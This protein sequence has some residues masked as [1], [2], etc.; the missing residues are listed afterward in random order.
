MS[1]DA[2]GISTFLSPSVTSLV[3]S[4]CLSLPSLFPFLYLLFV[5][6]FLSSLTFLSLPIGLL[7]DSH[8][9]WI[10]VI[11][12]TFFGTAFATKCGTVICCEIWGASLCTSNC[13][14]TYSSNNSKAIGALCGVQFSAF[15]ANSGVAFWIANSDAALNKSNYGAALGRIGV[16]PDR[17]TGTVHSVPIKSRRPAGHS[18]PSAVVHLSPM[19]D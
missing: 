2:F 10:G 18:T 15:C 17:V 1:F 16:S 5:L 7:L 12:G 14:V 19:V 3:S 11:C 8:L 13:G 9:A 4:S 6:T